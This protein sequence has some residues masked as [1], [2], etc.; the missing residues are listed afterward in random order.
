MQT[1]AV[2]A[3]VG[4]KGVVMMMMMMLVVTM[5]GGQTPCSQVDPQLTLPCVC[6]TSGQNITIN[7]DN[8][9]FPGDFP[10]L[11]FKMKIVEFT[12]RSAGIQALRGQLFTASDLPLQKVD[13][14]R[15]SIRRL[16][17]DVLEGL[18]PHLLH[19]RLDHNLLG[20]NYNPIFSSSEIAKLTALQMLNLAYNHI[21]D[22]DTGLLTSLKDLEVLHLEGNSF[23][24][25]PSDALQGLTNLKVLTLQENN[26]DVM[27]R[28]SLAAVPGL[29]FLNVSHN[30][31]INIEEEALTHLSELV[32][33]DLSYNRLAS[34][35]GRAFEGLT[36]L[37]ELD[38]SS[39]FL[40]EVPADALKDLSKLR[41][42]VLHD[43]LIQTLGG[44]V[45]LGPLV[46]LEQL[47]LTRNNI[48]EL[49]TGTF[50]QLSGLRILK[51]AVNSMRQV[52]EDALDGLT[53]L[54]SLHLDDDKILSIPWTAL[55]K[56]RT[57][58]T[59]SL[60]YNRVGVI[61]SS[62]LQTLTGLHRLSIAHNIIRELPPGTFSNF[63]GLESLNLFGNQLQNLIPE[64][65][66][67]L[68]ETLK[69][70]NLGL[71]RLSEL[72]QFDFPSLNSLV[73]S[74]NNITSLPS[75][76]F[77]LL[78][79]LTIL[80]LSENHL[81]LLPVTLLHPVRKL[82]TLDLSRNRIVE[83]RPGQFNESFINVI[84][85]QNNEIKEIPSEAFT[86]LLFLHTLD[87][88]HNTIRSIS[89]AAFMNIP[90][91]HF[92]RLNNNMLPSFKKE[93]FKLT[94]PA[95]N[96]ALRIL[97]LSHND[98][99]FLQPLAFQLHKKLS[100]LS[101]AHNR[102]TFF[103]SEIV[104]ELTDL[105]HLDVANNQ[106][107]S[108]ESNDF[109]NAPHLR[110]LN[111]KNNAIETVAESAFQNST[112]LQDLNLSQ[113]R[114]SELPE[115]VFLGI[116]RLD[117]DLSHNRLSSL[118]ETIFQR[119]KIQKLQSVNLAHN[120]FNQFPVKTLRQ[121]YFFLSSI[122]MAHNRISSVPSNADILVNIKTLDLSYNP[123]TPEAVF[124]LLSEPK[125]VR[126]LN[127][128]GTNVTEVPV[129]EARFLLSL[130]LSD[131]KIVEVKESSFE[132][133]Q[134]LQDLD[135]SHNKIPNL[136]YGL[137]MAWPKV[138]DLRILDISHNPL[139]YIV[140][141]DFNYLS[142]LEVL[143]AA[144]LPRVNRIERLA[145]SPLRSLRELHMHTLPRIAVLDVRGILEGHPG[146]EVV[147]IELTDREVHDQLHPAFYPRLHSLTVRGQSIEA[148]SGGAFAGINSPEL[149]IGLV[150]TSISNL[151][152]HF[153]FPVPMSSKIL[154]DIS[155]S[156][157]TSLSP[158]FL[159]TLDSRQRHLLLTG[160]GSNPLFCDCNIRTLR[161]WLIGRGS[162][163]NLFNVT[164]SAPSS[165]KGSVLTS[166]TEAELTCEG[167][168]TT[169]TT[170]PP[171]FTTTKRRPTTTD[172]II[173]FDD[174][175]RKPSDA[176]NEIDGLG[177]P[178][179][180][181]AG[182]TNMDTVIIGIVGGVVAFV[183]LLIIIICL[184]RL[185][186]DSQYRG[187]PLAG[188]LALRNHGNCTCLK[189][190]PPPGSWGG[191]PG[192]Y[193]PPPSS[194][195]GTLKMMPPPATPIPPAYGT[196]GANSGRN[197]YPNP[198]YYMG[199]P[200]ES[201]HEL[202]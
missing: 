137:A 128:A 159:N 80:D 184:I 192:P 158:Q 114:I 172:N 123:L 54:E 122:N 162:R 93:Y 64:S 85:L 112:Q 131:N 41:T 5:V 156:S 191:Y 149:T 147:D 164:C 193:P 180:S 183:A 132:L 52:D 60:D 143:H 6:T 13:F 198:Q 66:S 73:L 45:A 155:D 87:L 75:D 110:E 65:L 175:T 96:T 127:L 169:T 201:E 50:R 119:K 177:S 79:E 68:R 194:R 67:G 135:I 55:A 150:N 106:I 9:A 125:T 4:M 44:V 82:S 98:I 151:L 101:L 118:P 178:S 71:N 3:A 113:N 103:P 168:P 26:I 43:N 19:L 116:A 22:L 139:A 142:N 121:Q 152:S 167:R 88:S 196:V 25:L 202:R 145:L 197:F 10:L 166:L 190:P 20:N 77:V 83:I 170:D 27:K 7:C 8:V 49:P 140:R 134:N 102:L 195:A 171:L 37:E 56:V 117:L 99:T 31:I 51:L 29:V 138:P 57:L 109:A 107:K 76:A 100:W 163:D 104:G 97:D 63:T 187:G 40:T 84:N 12:Q 179:R 199:Y 174:M 81:S 185:R 70:L 32:T 33:L 61:S 23:L 59:L 39:N 186:S 188:N 35:R 105:E 47:D 2:V 36:N 30:R 126:H 115:D 21:R 153:F 136:S 161:R 86:D 46:S 91:I 42:L 1:G 95:P 129:I 62:S 94:I 157:I 148:L 38:L 48:G 133:T 78:P 124:I 28:S 17:K 144:Y 108:L 89:D 146:L 53:S 111:L 181:S 182:L 120:L 189:P 16:N 58:R 154:L 11:P 200:S 34:L 173:T 160:L 15:N 72:P 130:N 74:K 14:S 90:H 18:E 24:S 92:L 176:E 141:G 165:L 69:E